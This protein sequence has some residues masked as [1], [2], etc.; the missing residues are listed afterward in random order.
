MD[1]DQIAV[2]PK[3]LR[4]RQGVTGVGGGDL[5]E[6]EDVSLPQQ[7]LGRGGEREPA[8][9]GE[10]RRRRG[11]PPDRPRPRHHVQQIAPGPCPIV[12]DKG[13]AGAGIEKAAA[14]LGHRLIRPAREDEP[15][16]A[17]AFPGWLRQRIEAIIWTLKNQLGL[18]RHNA[19]HT[20]GL[21]AR[22][23]RRI[24]ALIAV[25]WHNWNIGAPVKRSLIAYDH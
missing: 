7:R 10:R 21:W 2:E 22:I 13:F 19:R 11:R 25:I 1:V 24:L 4:H 8:P 3:Q 16:P 20:D 12:C 14:D 15:G 18:E 9:V 17:P 23:S 5:G 6:R